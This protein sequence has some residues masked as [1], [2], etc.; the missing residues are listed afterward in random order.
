MFK[1][2]GFVGPVTQDFQSRHAEIIKLLDGFQR[3]PPFTLRRLIELLIDKSDQY[4]STH[5]YMN[6]LERILSVTSTIL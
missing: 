4:T 1:E 3:A 2:K 6:G 5:K